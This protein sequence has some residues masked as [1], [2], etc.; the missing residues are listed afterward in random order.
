MSF[1]KV[2]LIIFLIFITIFFIHKLIPQKQIEIGAWTEGLFDA[3]TESLHPEKLHEFEK[4]ID[5]KVTIAHFY[6]GWEALSDPKLINELSTLN[7]NGWKPILN[8]NPYF[9]SECST[10]NISLYKAIASGN[11]DSFLHKAGKNLSKVKKPFYLLFAWEMN[12]KDLEWSIDY[13]KSSP[14]DFIAAWQHIYTIFKN[15]KA[16]KIIWVFCPNTEGNKD[17]SYDEIYPGDSFVDWTGIDG[18]NWGTTQS[19]SHWQ[20]F[21]DVFS[22]SYK[23]LIKIAPNKP[24]MIAEVNST[25][26]GGNKSEW[27]KD[28]LTNELP[29]NFP[30]IK[31][32]VFYNED[33]TST[34]NVN[35]KIDITEKTLNSFKAGIHMNY[36]K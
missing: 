4:L 30:N 19:W 33:R 23:H 15:E 20:S 32:I 22:N 16:T 28:M 2:I 8:V 14:N 36:Y 17:I 31:A 21:Q 27:Y 24:V 25:T 9:F 5:K 10:K 29:N 34:E 26:E 13:T 11:C 1:K 18:Y 6:R 3:K 35:W 12:N 7:N